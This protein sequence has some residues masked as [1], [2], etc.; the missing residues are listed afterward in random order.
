MKYKIKIEGGKELSD[1]LKK[2]GVKV[3][4]EILENIMEECAEIPRA[5]ASRRAPRRTGELA[6]KIMI[7]EVMEKK[8]K[9]EIEIGPG[10]GKEAFWGRFDEFGTGP[11]K[12]K[13]GKFTGSMP[14]KPFLRP[15]LDEN[16]E[17]IETT[18]RQGIKE[19]I[20]RAQR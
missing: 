15:A 12:T 14:A 11:R 6:S 19:L 8:E 18:F 3:N 7:G 17:Q 9:F 20:D 13:K 2:L 4:R 10:P 16:K 1:S 5:D